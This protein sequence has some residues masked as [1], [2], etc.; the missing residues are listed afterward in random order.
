MVIFEKIS[1]NKLSRTRPPFAKVFTN[2]VIREWAM[3]EMMICLDVG[4]SELMFD[5]G[6]G[7]LNFKNCKRIN[8][9]G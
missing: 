5:S 4:G 6:F 8:S 7:N 9:T 2:K 1:R 3:M